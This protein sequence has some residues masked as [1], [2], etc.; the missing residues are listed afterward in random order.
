MSRYPSPY[1]RPQPRTLDY[2]VSAGTLVSFMN[3]VYAWMCVGLA[4]TAVVAWFV[5]TQTNLLHSFTP[6]LFIGLFIGQLALVWIIS[7]AVQSL[8]ATMATALFLLYAAI[9]GVLFSGIILVYEP[10]I[11][12]V[13]FGTAAG[14][15]AAM[16][17]VGFITKKDLTSLGG[18][19]LVA[20]I[21]LIIASIVN[22][23][24]ANT[25]LDWII[26]YAGVAIFLGLTAYDTQKLKNIAAATQDDPKLAARL[27]VSGSLM[28]YLDFINLFLFLLRI[29]GK[30]RE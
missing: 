24:W 21:G 28:L 15:F 9:N 29:L 23:F 30:A 8:N 17:V 25:Q 6:G 1:G 3:L 5:A 26:N 11:I 7:A 22:A 18:F 16:S 10:T 19:L 2:G 12:G 20:L 4:T 13:A 14:L 27:A